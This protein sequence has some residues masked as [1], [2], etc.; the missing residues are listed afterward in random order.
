MGVVGEYAGEARHTINTILIVGFVVGLLAFFYSKWIEQGGIEQGAVLVRKMIDADIN[1][2]YAGSAA[3]IRWTVSVFRQKK[4]QYHLGK[5][6]H[7]RP[8]VSLYAL[9]SENA[10]GQMTEWEVPQELLTGLYVDDDSV[11]VAGAKAQH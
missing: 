1:P 2:R 8:V 4:K 5:E 7:D 6:F 11:K 9:R 3:K 10:A